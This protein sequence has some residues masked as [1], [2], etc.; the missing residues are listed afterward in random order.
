MKF[1]S[2]LFYLS[3]A[4]IAGWV[5]FWPVVF[6]GQ[7]YSG[8]LHVGALATLILLLVSLSGLVVLR[9]QKR[10]SDRARDS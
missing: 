6:V 10:R 7:Q 4:G 8:I 9:M 1:I 2:F 3:L 5:F